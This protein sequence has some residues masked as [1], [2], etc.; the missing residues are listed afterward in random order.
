MT[1]IPP[2]ISVV[3][4][5]APPPPPVAVAAS[6]PAIPDVRCPNP[7]CRAPLSPPYNGPIE[8][9]MCRWKGELYVFDPLPVAVE[10][11]EQALPEDSCCIHHPT[12]KAAAI[13]AGTGDYICTLCA[14]ELNGETYS[15]AYLDTAG[16]EKIGKAFDR[17]LERPDNTI[18]TLL[19]CC[20]IPYV[21]FV[22]I[23]TAFVWIPYA[24][25][26]YFKCLRMRRENPLFARVFGKAR[27]V[28]IP[29]LLGVFSLAWV[30]VVIAILAALL[31][32][33]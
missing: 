11:A 12:K 14:V 17:Y 18:V 23:P 9:G 6:A 22:L 10:H 5:T 26:L 8:C 27:V 32:H 13:C 21:N 28:T 25:F 31:S 20:F 15:A 16:K 19:I 29:I 33:H 7:L 24:V 30:G 2:P 4:A 3:P 1:A